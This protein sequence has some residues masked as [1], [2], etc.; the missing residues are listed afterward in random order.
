MKY[1]AF[2]A[3]LGLF[4]IPWVSILVFIYIDIILV[5]VEYYFLFKFGLLYSFRTGKH[6]PKVF[7]RSKHTATIVL[8]TYGLPHFLL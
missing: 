1:T 8:L 3:N 5:L 6:F 4:R 7:E 2:V